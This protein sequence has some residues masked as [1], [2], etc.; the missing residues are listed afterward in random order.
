MKD[1]LSKKSSNDLQHGSILKLD[2]VTSSDNPKSN[3]E[4]IVQEIHDILKSY[5]KVARK[6]FVDN[7]IMQAA[8][9]YLVTGPMTPVKVFSP[10]FV[11]GLSD[12]QL[13]EIA[14]EDAGT[15]RKRAAL[16]KEIATL[17]AARKIVS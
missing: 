12:G 10:Q 6:R 13:Q 7:V 1:K 2:D 15:K 3:K 17:E 9:Y 14:G 8:D 11:S 4:H 5:Y 16:S